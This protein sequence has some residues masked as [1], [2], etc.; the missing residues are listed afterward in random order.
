MEQKGI[1]RNPKVEV[2]NSYS[3][4]TDR[5]KSKWTGVLSR[6]R[7]KPRDQEKTI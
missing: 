5:S 4:R 7:V 3:G 2:E 1:I 6:L